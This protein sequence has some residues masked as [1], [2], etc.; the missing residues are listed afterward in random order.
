MNR[1]R[2]VN[3]QQIEL[4]GVVF[5]LSN[6]NVLVQASADEQFYFNAAVLF[7]AFSCC[8]VCNSLQFAES[9]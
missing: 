7:P 3:K 2:L 8:V 4:L 5:D 9:E 6:L 1:L